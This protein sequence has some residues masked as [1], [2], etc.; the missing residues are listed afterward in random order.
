MTKRYINVAYKDREMAKRL[1]A[2][3]DASVKR[4]YCPPGSAL[5]KVYS[6]R[7]ASTASSRTLV[8]PSA[9]MAGSHPG[10]HTGSQ[11]G[12]HMDASQTSQGQLSLLA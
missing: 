4:W 8:M 2:R 1:G 9:L 7:Q 11:T 12:P 10:S 3:W 5:A 6:W